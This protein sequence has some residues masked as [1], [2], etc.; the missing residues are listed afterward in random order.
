M[1]FY[2]GVNDPGWLSRTD[3]PLFVSR[4]RLVRM[5]SVPMAKGRWMLDSGG[6][7]ELQMYGEWRTLPEQYARETELWAGTIGNLD[8]A[9]IQDWMCEPVVISGGSAG[10]LKFAG[11][12]KSVREHQR[13]TIESYLSLRRLAPSV[14]WMPVLQGWEIE[15]Y[16][17]HVEEY[18][19]FGVDLTEAPIVGVG[20]VCRR[21]GTSEIRDIFLNLYVAG[22][23]CHGFGVKT[24]GLKRSVNYMASSDSLAWS[25]AARRGSPLPGH[26]HKKCNH[27][28][29]YAL[30]WRDRVVRLIERSTVQRSVFAR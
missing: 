7:T 24:L 20:S 18:K 13:L 9:A 25:F 11:T 5:G 30:L 3:V 8:F 23:D 19:T 1:I 2:L 6:F 12:G 4:R 10:G 21:Q 28:L 16:L 27:C 26:S 22:I 29:E 17:F 14:P 15:D